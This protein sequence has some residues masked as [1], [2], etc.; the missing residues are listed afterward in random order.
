MRP[1]GEPESSEVGRDWSGSRTDELSDEHDEI[2]QLRNRLAE[3]ERELEEKNRALAK[4]WHRCLRREGGSVAMRWRP[5]S[6]G[7]RSGLITRTSSFLARASRWSRREVPY[8]LGQVGRLAVGRRD[9]FQ[10]ARTRHRQRLL[11]M[12]SGLFDGSWFRARYPELDVDD[13]LDFFL[14]SYEYLN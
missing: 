13:P 10:K 4:A 14:E 9:E 6:T 12:R 2:E 8:L 5:R 11:V 7:R 3:C 1:E